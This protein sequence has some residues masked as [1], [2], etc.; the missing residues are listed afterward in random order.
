MGS[1][2][3][4]KVISDFRLDVFVTGD[5][6]LSSRGSIAKDSSILIHDSFLYFPVF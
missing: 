2:T 6:T 1:V 3:S 4:Y 5:A